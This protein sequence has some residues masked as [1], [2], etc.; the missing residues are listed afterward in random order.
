MVILSCRTCGYSS[1]FN[2]MVIDL[3]EEAKQPMPNVS[4]N[5]YEISQTVRLR[6]T[7]FRTLFS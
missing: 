1:L 3:I 7:S 6:E 2:S 4:D 5:E